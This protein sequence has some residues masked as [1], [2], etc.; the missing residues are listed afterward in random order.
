MAAEVKHPLLFRA[1]R[2]VLVFSLVF[3]SS[4]GVEWALAFGADDDTVGTQVDAQQPATSEN[5][6]VG[7]GTSSESG[8]GSND[9]NGSGNTND[10]PG[11]DTGGTGDNTPTGPTEEELQ[12]ER[13]VAAA[14]AVIDAVVGLRG[15][16]ADDRARVDAVLAQL[17]S[18]TPEQQALV[19]DAVKQELQ[20]ISNHVDELIAERD[21]NEDEFTEEERFIASKHSEGSLV[22]IEA[23]S[24]DENDPSSEYAKE[25]IRNVRQTADEQG[26]QTPKISTINGMLQIIAVPKWQSDTELESDWKP[27]ALKADFLKWSVVGNEGY[28]EVQTDDGV[29]TIKSLSEG[30]FLVTCTVDDGK[31]EKGEQVDTDYT[32]LIYSGFSDEYPGKSFTVM[33]SVEVLGPYIDIELLQS[34]GTTCAGLESLSL[35]TEQLN[36]YAF[37]A[38]VRV[39]DQVKEGAIDEFRCTS[40]SGLKE[41]SAAKYGELFDDLTWQVLDADRNPVDERIATISDMGVLEFKGDIDKDG[42][43]IVRASSPNGFNQNLASAEVRIG[44]WVEDPQGESHPQE[45][46]RIT[47]NARVDGSASGEDVAGSSEAAEPNPE[48]SNPE[49]SNPEGEGVSPNESS[50]VPGDGVEGNDAEGAEQNDSEKAQA[51]DKI[52]TVA[53]IEALGKNVET[54]T[55]QGSDGLETVKGEGVSLKLLLADAGITDLTQVNSID[56]IDYTG[57]STSVTWADISSGTQEPFVAVRSRV[58]T[59]KEGS[60]EGAA[61]VDNSGNADNPDNANGSDNAELLDNTRFRLLFYGSASIDPDALRWIKHIRVNVASAEGGSEEGD[62]AVRVDYVPVPRGKQAVLSAIPSQAIGSARFGFSWETSADGESWTPVPNGEVQT[63][64]LMTD[65]AQ[66]G[67][68]YR[69]VLETDMLDPQTGESLGATSKPVQIKEGSGFMAILAYDPPIAGQTAIFQSSV[70]AYVDGQQISI[71]PAQL[72][73]EWQKSEDGGASWQRIDGATGPSFAVPTEPIAEQKPAANAGDSESDASSDAAQEPEP[74]TLIYV[75]VVVT[76]TDTRIPE[77][78]RI[79]ESNAQPLTVRVG[80]GDDP[81]SDNAGTNDDVDQQGSAPQL[82]IDAQS[83]AEQVPTPPTSGSIG[84]MTEIT[85]IHVDNTPRPSVTEEPTPNPI[86]PQQTQPE[87]APAQASSAVNARELKPDELLINPEITALVQE[88]EAAIDK[89]VTNSRPGAR[90]TQLSTV[91]PTNDDVRRILADNPFAPFAIPLGLGIAVAGG[92]EKLLAFRREID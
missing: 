21:N 34:D 78:A 60:G 36:S 43:I 79:A 71:D 12:H 69:V 74:V 24:L 59:E 68:W 4:L 1:I 91:E 35:S 55:M 33:F 40:T 50:D 65:D 38:N 15:A 72:K 92:L 64:R 62:L 67:R 61:G 80:G 8:G 45:T 41:A 58:L 54:F 23:W 89:A 87:Q 5:S 3:W 2:I 47:S 86:T 20:D 14:Q 77:Q 6:E 11:T 83:P 73:Y 52:Y 57:A 39:Y 30:S 84:G 17:A 22:D 53:Q 31:N 49:G 46:L 13:D 26:Y 88:Q 81:N 18:L 70:E 51:I 48:G 27:K 63:L 9:G 37:Q 82:P 44:T 29:L 28:A 10:A 76:T 19:P 85:N 90:W 66:I 32:N 42:P 7:A 16:T 56:F 25:P 75:R